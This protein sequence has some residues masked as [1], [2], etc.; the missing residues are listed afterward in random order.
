MIRI[1]NPNRS[2]QQFLQHT[3]I[4]KILFLT[5]YCVAT[6]WMG[7]K[8]VLL[9]F[10]LLGNLHEVDQLQSGS[11]KSISHHQIQIRRIW[12][13]ILPKWRVWES[14]EGYQMHY[15]HC[16]SWSICNEMY[17]KNWSLVTCK[18]QLVPTLSCVR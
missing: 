9:N 2:N 1:S 4:K 17:F 10:Y 6:W 18:Y 15:P 11:S 13:P 12:L 8:N 7:T 3:H 16:S 14:E 5:I